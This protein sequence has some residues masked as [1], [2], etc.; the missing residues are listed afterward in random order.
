MILW[1]VRRSLQLPT[2]PD[3]SESRWNSIYHIHLRSWGHGSTASCRM[4]QDRID[5][6]NLSRAKSWDI[7]HLA[8]IS[9][10]VITRCVMM[11]LLVIIG[12]R[13]N[14]RQKRP[15]SR[16]VHPIFVAVCAVCASVRHDVA[17]GGLNFS[18][19]YRH[20]Y[21]INVSVRGSM[22][23]WFIMR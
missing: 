20:E 1:Y 12:R 2:G 14:A 11:I 6:C 23:K 21:F 5:P 19:V 17:L 15:S 7:A 10:S 8:G 13:N 4:K 18:K 3:S 9:Q 22:K 16:A